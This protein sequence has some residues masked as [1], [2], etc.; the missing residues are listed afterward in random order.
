[1]VKKLIYKDTELEKLLEE[2][3]NKINASEA[4]IIRIKK[5]M[6]RIERESQEVKRK[7]SL[8]L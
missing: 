3:K 7:I 2:S 4:T 6:K 8:L 1:M 5:E